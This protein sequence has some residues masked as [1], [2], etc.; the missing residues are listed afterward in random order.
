[1]KMTCH[2]D[3]LLAVFQTVATVAPT[4]S[5]KPILQKVKLEAD[6]ERAVLMATDLEVA[7]RAVVTDVDVSAPGSVLL[8]AARCGAILR[9]SSDERIL[10]ETDGTGIRIQGERS[11][12]HLLA[13]NPDEFPAVAT[14]DEQR[15][16][17]LPARLLRELVRRTLFAADAEGGRY[18]LGGALLEFASDRITAVGTDGRRLAKMEGPAESVGGHENQDS[19]TIVPAR[20]LQLIERTLGDG[21]AEVLLAA[22]TNDLLVQSPRAVIYTRLIEGRYPKWRDVIPRRSDG[23]RIQLTVGPVY[24]AVR[25]SAIVASDES[26]GVDFT[27][28]EGSLVLAGSSAD[29][30]QSRVELPIPYEGPAITLTLDHRFMADFFRVLDPEATFTFEVKDSA[31]AALLTTEDGYEYVVMPLSRER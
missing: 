29:Y 18:A 15:Y 4:R 26:R 2:R 10:I 8:H 31:S 11:R 27:F 30:G 20:S 6:L 14:F 5:P 1:M 21:D 13:E 28:G 19:T 9:E 16:H 17:R 24:A 25:Q 7:I 12:F 3:K 23:V 22:R